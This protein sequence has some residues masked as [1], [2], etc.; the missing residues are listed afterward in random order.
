TSGNVALF[1]T[2]LVRLMEDAN[3]FGT[4]QRGISFLSPTF[5]AT[6]VS[7]PSNVP[8]GVFLA[9]AFVVQNGQIIGQ[10]SQQFF[11]QKTGFERFLGEASR[12]QPLLYGLACVAL[13]LATG[14]LGGVL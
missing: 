13:A 3:L 14:W 1:E 5:F 8:N 7:L 10:R 9:Q 12:N 11:V 4:A 6:R 2:E